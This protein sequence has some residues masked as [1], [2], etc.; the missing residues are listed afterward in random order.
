MSRKYDPEKGGAENFPTIS[1]LKSDTS[2]KTSLPE[3]VSPKNGT[4]SSGTWV[5]SDGDMILRPLRITRKPNEPQGQVGAIN[6][7]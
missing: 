4:R 5:I 6:L 7:S 3:V 2:N 1:D